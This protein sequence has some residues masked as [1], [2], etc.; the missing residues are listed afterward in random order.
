MNGIACSR[1]FLSLSVRATRTRWSD[2]RLI[3]WRCRCLRAGI[4]RP[5]SVVLRRGWGCRLLRLCGVRRSS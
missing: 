5:G 3:W 2:D 4:E 1:S